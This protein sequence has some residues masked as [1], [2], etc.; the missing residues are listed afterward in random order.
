VPDF[1]DARRDSRTLSLGAWTYGGGT[2]SAPGEPMY[3]DG[4][5]VSADLFSVFGVALPQGRNFRADED[6]SGAPPLAILSDGL[7]RSRY[8][9]DPHVI[10]KPLIFDGKPYSVIGVAPAGLSLPAE[11]DIFTP[12]GQN[13]EPRTRNRAAHFLHVVGR[14]RADAKLVQ[15]QADLT[16]I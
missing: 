10:G 15:A 2:V 1:Q 7:G 8:G 13:T 12:L 11:A 16:L 4:L 14:L 3:A 6:R 5:Y 9:G